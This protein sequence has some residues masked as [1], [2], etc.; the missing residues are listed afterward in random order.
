MAQDTFIK[1]G[2][3]DGESQD[4]LH[5]NEIDVIGWRWKVSQQ[6]AM[7]SGSGG[8]AGKA[9]VSDLEFTH[10]LDRASP[11]LIRYCFTGKHIDQVK[12]TVRKAGGLPFEYLKITMYDVVITQVE[13]IG[14][15]EVCHE[16]VCLS[17]STMKQEYFVQNALGGSGGAVTAT[18]YIKNN[19]TN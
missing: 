13:P 15:G 16:E 8:G 3:I 10:Q 4:A 14:G 11:N 7:M 1:I 5:L 19:T 12:L 9:T 6:S 18:L 2:G 17:F